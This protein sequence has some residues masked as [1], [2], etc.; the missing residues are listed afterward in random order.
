[1]KTQFLEALN[2]RHA[3]KVFDSDKKISNNDFAFILEAA[4]LSPSSFGIEPWK[5]LVVQNMTL[6]NKLKE[7]TWGAQGQLPTASHFVLI[8]N[9]RKSEMKFDSDYVSN[10]MKDVQHH[11]EELCEKRKQMMEV[12]QQS[13]FGILESD[14]EMDAWASKQTYIALSNMLTSAASIGIDS[15]P[16]EGFQRDKVNALLASDFGIDTSK[17]TISVMAAFGHRINEPRDKTRQ[18]MDQIVDWYE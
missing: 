3:C 2:F 4:R 10:F 6:R 16:I 9:R 17:F 8:L 5:F 12:F 13:D 1:M 7:I 11:P 14:R 18:S 15:C